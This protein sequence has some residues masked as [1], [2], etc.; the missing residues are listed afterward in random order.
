MTFIVDGTNGATFPDSSTQASAS[1]VLQVVQG[2]YSTSTSTSGTT[3]IDTGVT[4][5]I[6]PK[7][8]TS[9][10][11]VLATMNGVYN[12]GN[13]NTGIQLAIL[14]NSTNLNAFCNYTSYTSTAID[15][16]A[17]ASANYLDS[18]AT[19]SATT[20]KVQFARNAGSGTVRVQANSDVSSITL[21]EIAQ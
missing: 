1:K 14:R 18:P 17:G 6:T 16:I 19:T 10:I 12:G 15:I 4:A 5:T 3:L 2:T 21:L 20:Y 7:F 8:S 11:L 9:K 13:A